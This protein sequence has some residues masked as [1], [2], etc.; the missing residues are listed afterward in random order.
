MNMYVYTEAQQ[1]EDARRAE[2]DEEAA[3]RG[4][5]V[6]RL[7]ARRERGLPQ[8]PQSNPTRDSGREGGTGKGGEGARERSGGEGRGG[9]GSGAERRR[10]KGRYGKDGGDRERQE[11]ARAASRRADP[12]IQGG[13]GARVDGPT[14]RPDRPTWRISSSGSVPSRSQTKCVCRVL[15]GYSWGTHGVL[16]GY[17]WGTHGTQEYLEDLVERQR[18]E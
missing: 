3:E 12:F 18:A 17:S 4:V 6:G 16:M 5:P 1:L 8:R 10:E 9:E 14:H 15:K 2:E 7:R 13:A 11:D